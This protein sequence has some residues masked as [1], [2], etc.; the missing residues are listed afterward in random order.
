M[1]V[2]AFVLVAILGAYLGP[3]QW[4]SWKA[5]QKRELGFAM[6]QERCK[7]KSGVFIHRTVEDV[8]GI[9]LVN[10]RT[11]PEHRNQGE[12]EEDQYRLSDPYGEDG[13]D[14]YYLKTFLRGFHHQRKSDG[15]RLATAPPRVGY[16]F[17]EAIDP[18]DGKIYRYTGRIDQPWLRDKSYGEWVR[19][20]V[21][22]RT[23]IPQ[24]TAR[25]GVKFEDISTREEREHWI[26]G[27]SLKVIDLQANEVIAERVGY[28]V[29]WAQGS[30]A[31]ARQ[32]WTFAAD[33]AC[34]SFAKAEP[35]Q[36][37]AR[38]NDHRGAPTLDFVEK[39]LKP[40]TREK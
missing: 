1:A 5:Q 17:V 26:A 15:P 25:Y 12:R 8:E 37:A 30:R 33:C 23:A 7:A 35:L 32:P 18:K 40:I 3:G 27:S 21:L 39:S 13:T 6:W 19:E 20:F 9:Y 28:M 38:G 31:G 10:V 34:P 36:C 2:G 24:R 29:D 11:S 16:D 14:D 22:D 4:R